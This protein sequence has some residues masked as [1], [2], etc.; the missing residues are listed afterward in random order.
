M[1]LKLNNSQIRAIFFALYD[2]LFTID[3]LN[4]ED[5]KFHVNGIMKYEIFMY[6]G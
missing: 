6:I 3:A 1:F 5:W 2:E 4:V